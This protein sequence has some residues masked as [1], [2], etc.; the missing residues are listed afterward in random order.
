MENLGDDCVCL[1]VFYRCRLCACA[2][3][4]ECI[5]VC[6]DGSG[7]CVDDMCMCHVTCV[8]ASLHGTRALN[9]RAH[10]IL[11]KYSDLVWI[12]QTRIIG[13]CMDLFN[14]NT[15]HMILIAKLGASLLIYKSK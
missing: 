8:H 3:H 9:R 15:W 14:D 13:P 5:R 11:C 2:V 4:V 10:T 6:A 1:W 12:F 7:W